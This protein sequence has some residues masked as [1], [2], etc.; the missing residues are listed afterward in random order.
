MIK[1][2]TAG[3]QRERPIA[4]QARLDLAKGDAWEERQGGAEEDAAADI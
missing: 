1:N 3:R 2:D 4:R